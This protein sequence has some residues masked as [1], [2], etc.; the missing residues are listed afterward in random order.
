MTATSNPSAVKVAT[1][2]EFEK[3][4]AEYPIVAA[5]DVES[6]PAR[7][8]QVMR[9]KLRD[10]CSIRM[11]KR[12]VMKKA[13]EHVKAKKHG[14]EQLEPHMKGMTALLFTKQNP[15]ALFKTAKA[16][17]SKA[18]AKPG[19]TAPYDI[20]VPAGPTPFAPGPIIGE[21]GSFGIKTGVE[22]GKVAIKADSV[23]AKE[24][25]IINAKLAGLLSR[26][27]IQPMEIGLNITAVYENGTIMT[28]SVL[29]IDEKQ[30][31]ADLRLAVA[32]G[33]A[34]A[35]DASILDTETRTLAVQRAAREAAS[36]G[37]T[38]SLPAE[39]LGELSEAEFAVYTV[40]TSGPVAAQPSE[41]AAMPVTEKNEEKNE[42]AAAEGLGSLFG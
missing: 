13:I 5:V 32:Q 28:K 35:L 14:I 29:D 27:G 12:R 18:A 40:M 15:F 34:L 17:K 2:K 21:L 42:E 26:L 6:L 9:E 33:I 41:A 39:T 20:V 16:S 37:V 10:S 23:V 38:A 22:G 1:A 4:L 19:Q 25:A 30:Y 24:G 36:I 11:T 3:L 31:L 7:Q 8:L